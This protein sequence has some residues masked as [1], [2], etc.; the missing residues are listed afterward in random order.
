[1]PLGKLK[2][3]LDENK[4]K[5]VI[6]SHSIAYTTQEIAAMGKNSHY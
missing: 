4:I 3:Y 1:M 2:K 6:K 5:Y